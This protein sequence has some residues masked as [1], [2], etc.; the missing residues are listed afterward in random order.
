MKRDGVPGRSGFTDAAVEG[1]KNR[2]HLSHNKAMGAS[3]G[4]DNNLTS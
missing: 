4:S 3:I 2:V 1:M